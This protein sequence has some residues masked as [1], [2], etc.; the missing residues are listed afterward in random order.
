MRCAAGEEAEVEQ[1]RRVGLLGPTDGRRERGARNNK[2]VQ[3]GRGGKTDPPPSSKKGAKLTASPPSTTVPRIGG[4]EDSEWRRRRRR[5]RPWLEV[6]VTRG[7]AIQEEEEEE[8]RE[9]RRSVSEAHTTA[10]PYS[11]PPPP[12]PP[13]PPPPRPSPAAEGASAIRAC[14]RG[15][16]TRERET[17]GG[18]DG[19][20]VKL[21][22]TRMF[23]SSLLEDWKREEKEGAVLLLLLLETKSWKESKRILD[24]IPPA[25]L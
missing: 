11:A 12:L 22:R 4:R 18:R 17:R 5:R 24:S 3:D 2:Y 19:R 6:G 15:P 20:A 13:P 1:V 21:L 23:C 10:I 7:H 9:P 25:L 8:E 14:L 16:T